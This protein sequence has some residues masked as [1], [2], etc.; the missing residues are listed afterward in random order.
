MSNLA[1][2]LLVFLGTHFAMSHP[3]R[4]AMVGR[5]GERGFAGVH[6]AISLAAF[7]WIVVAFRAAPADVLWPA[8]PEL[9]LVAQIVMLPACLLVATG[10]FTRNPTMVMQRP[11]RDA[12]RGITA[13]TRHPVMWGAA[14]WAVA[15]MLANG[16][17]ATV[18]LA[19]GMGVLALAGA[20]GIDR[21]RLAS[22]SGY[23]AFMAQTSF[24]PFVA[25]A[26]GRAKLRL[27]D[28]GWKPVLGLVLYA[29]LVALH[30]WIT[31]LSAR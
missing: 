3:L 16:R 25:I 26:Q 7:A 21:R 24:V 30:P 22:Q 13:I 11:G 8:A 15:H 12:V 1:L 6:S 19:A 4:A 14:L 20:Y 10:Y 18:L 17:A 29:A 27:A 9:R 2:A 5:L 23:A 31:G 28:L